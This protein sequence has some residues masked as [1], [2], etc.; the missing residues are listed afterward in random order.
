MDHQL[1][2]EVATVM[3]QLA[4]AVETDEI[5]WFL[6]AEAA[7]CAAALHAHV[8]PEGA[9]D[10]QVFCA[11]GNLSWAQYVATEGTDAEAGGAAL[12]FLAP[13]Y[14]IDAE[15]VPEP[16]HPVMAALLD[17]SGTTGIDAAVAYDLG[18]GLLEFY[19]RHQYVTALPVAERL[20]TVAAN[21]LPPS[22][23]WHGSALSTLSAVVA[24]ESALNPD[25][26][27]VEFAVRCADA[28]V[29]A[30]PGDPPEQ[31]RRLAN[32]GFALTKLA[33]RTGDRETALRGVAVHRRVLNEAAPDDPVRPLVTA[34]LGEALVGIAQRFEDDAAL[35]EGAELLRQSLAVTPPESRAYAARLATL[36]TALL[37]AAVASGDFGPAIETFRRAADAAPPGTERIVAL[38][39]L[40]Y[41]MYGQALASSGTA[42]LDEAEAMALRALGD[43]PSGH[44]LRHQTLF[45]L[46]SVRAA[47]FDIRKDPADLDAALADAREALELTPPGDH[48]LT[49]RVADLADLLRE[50]DP[51]EAVEL[52]RSAL[53]KTAPDSPERTRLT[54]DLGWMLSSRPRGQHAEEGLRLLHACQNLPSPG[55][56][57]SARA[58][59]SLGIVLAR[60][61]ATWQEGAGLMRQAARLLPAG[62]PTRA[63]YLSALASQ[64]LDRAKNTL[65]PELFGA[66]RSLLEEALSEAA[67]GTN[68]YALLHSNLGVALV[69]H[70]RN[71]A[72]GE[73]LAESVRAHRTAA[74]N[75]PRGD[76]HYAVRLGNL[77][78]SLR[79]LAEHVSDV[80]LVDE[81][82]KLQREA[83]AA[84]SD[85]T[86]YRAL[87]L[88]QLG[89][90][91]RT[92]AT[93][94]VEPGRPYESTDHLR[95]AE[96]CLRE[97]V[98]LDRAAGRP[99]TTQLVALCNVLNHL[100]GDTGDNTLTDDVA[101]LLTT[102]LDSAEHPPEDRA[103]L[104]T[105]LGL[106]RWNRAAA[107][108][109]RNLLEAGLDT[110]RHAAAV[111][112][113]RHLTRPVVLM[114]LGAALRDQSLSIGDPAWLDEAI[115]VLTTALAES[116][117]RGHLRV[118]LLSNLTTALGRL[119]E[120]NGKQEVADRA[121]ALGREAVAANF[122]V[123]LARSLALMNL[124][125]VLQGIAGTA[126]D[127]EV[128]AEA[129]ATL[130]EAA[131]AMGDDHPRRALCLSNL[132]TAYWALTQMPD[133]LSPEAA[134]MAQFLGLGAV[135][136][137]PG[138]KSRKLL[139]QATA[140]A[141][142]A[143]DL[144]PD[145][146]PDRAMPA[147]T[148]ARSQLARAMLGERVDLAEAVRIGRRAAEAENAPVVVR[149][150]A[151]R[152]W[153]DAAAQAGLPADALAGYAYGVD[154]LPRVAPRGLDRMVQEDRLSI[155][156][157]LANDA[158]AFALKVGDP[159]RALALLEQG[160]G[161]LLAQALET[162]G[163][164]SPLRA[165]DPALAA[166]FEELREA[167]VGA[168]R[169]SVAVPVE[170][171]PED[172]I[173]TR[174]AAVR[175]AEQRQAQARAWDD[176]L[177]RIRALPGLEGFL[178]PP[179]TAELL[180]AA[181]DG[182]VV[183]VNI[184][185]Y[186]S[187]ALLV[188]A[189]GIAVV[190]LAEVSAMAAMDKATEFI[191]TVE[192]AYGAEGRDAVPAAVRALTE[193]LEWM[194][195]AIAE[196]VLDRLGLR[197]TPDEGAPWP[198][199]FWCPTGWASFLPLHAAG[200]H[201][202]GERATVLD[203]VVSSYTPTLR[204]LIRARAELAGRATAE[205]APL[206]ISLPETPGGG[207]LPGAAAEA[208]LIKGLFPDAAE[209]AG[210]DAT[211]EAVLRELPG[212]A[213]VHFGC[214]GVSDLDRPSEAGLQLHDGRLRAFDAAGLRMERPVLAVLAACSTS[215]GGLFVPD[216][217]I[218][219][220][221]SF[222]LAGYPHVV[223]TFWPVSDRLSREVTGEF[224][225]ALARD[226][227]AP[228][229]ALHRPI[230]RLRDRFAGAPHLWA[231]HAHTGP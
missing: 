88:T 201:L 4:A 69:V 158:A 66:G 207:G 225:H 57:F 34:N 125:V 177:E 90:S 222:Q 7:A 187:D 116:P 29:A 169:A 227:F 171:G 209:L 76:R 147:L 25:P 8:T 218:H 9:G 213:W 182:P 149:L 198:R 190:E 140:A 33:D 78:D 70:G 110:L 165:A 19:H 223:G 220:A 11:L 84:T 106:T 179:D 172:E 91:L 136:T 176:L 142:T 51:D 163:D 58:R 92:F 85:D 175:L 166:Q 132:A 150:H 107:I 228:A 197:L 137:D 113:P 153:G 63:D 120:I 71:I 123:R 115:D 27:V 50:K 151:A 21:A 210:P 202:D 178:R 203:R 6:S 12:F 24:Y 117:P 230:R 54:L 55:P 122:G 62:D 89:S 118:A 99:V 49:R 26:A 44:W 119:Y 214:H 59:F 22:E 18:T 80:A 48:K 229:A 160:R 52:L 189:G 134:G 215:R 129:I 184:S 216:E 145:G 42:G 82:I 156:F 15:A 41:A 40:A 43:T 98:E 17:Q 155:T 61:E 124:G 167:M 196:P 127:R 60:D 96:G 224:Y 146:H 100:A 95:E 64:Y 180:A 161:V 1:P 112:P 39:N 14:G 191:G 10:A 108:G 188:T 168:G 65:D 109:D 226:A 47:R 157:G 170:L 53:S 67:P 174:N 36:G 131:E 212:H 31:T 192:D 219:V 86:R 195:S 139:R 121:V 128:Q 73:L 143:I 16:L 111:L 3:E 13:V 35:E 221:S 199:L 164:V 45:V 79:S 46:S 231:A 185:R 135:V 97:A 23:P 138:R 162:R 28:A 2:G 103:L 148:F 77:G 126:G 159:A 141:R 94:A 87:C 206:L 102:E 194:W 183:V 75:T 200:R 217:V 133:D 83:V 32:L 101:H 93:L 154:L 204:A 130:E 81:A 72:D 38:A 5:G 193:A 114:N 68:R 74:A 152:A 20:L 186:R 173:R 181:V 104:L 30:T 208:D 144:T 105:T 205:P 37:G 211:V 56:G